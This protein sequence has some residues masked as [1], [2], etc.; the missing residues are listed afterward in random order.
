M[1]IYGM[2]SFIV[3]LALG[4]LGMSAAALP[5][6]R[7]TQPTQLL[8]IAEDAPSQP[9]AATSTEDVQERYLATETIE[10]CMKSWDPGTH[11]SK[12]AWRTTCERI[13]AERLP[14]VKKR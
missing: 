6:S 3:P 13:K 10:S 9:D 12:E 2:A 7:L 4:A 1:T 14:Y 8:L 11:M 5:A